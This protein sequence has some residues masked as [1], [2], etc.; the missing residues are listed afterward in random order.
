MRRFR[1]RNNHGRKPTHFG[2]IFTRRQAERRATTVATNLTFEVLE[3]RLQMAVVI[4]EFLAANS[5]GLADQDGDRS[6]WIELRNSDA[7]PVDLGG[8]YLTDDV[9]DLDKWQIPSTNLPGGG[10]LVIFAS[11]KDRAVSGQEL[12][13]NFSLEQ[14]G[15]FLALVMPDGTT[16][17][18][19]F[20]PFP[21]QLNDVSYGRGT[22]SIITESPIG[23]DAPL[24]VLVPQNSS[25]ATT[26]YTTGFNDSGWMSGTSGVGFDINGGTDFTPYVGTNIQTA[27]WNICSSAYI[28][29]PFDVA[30]GGELTTLKLRMR[31]DDGFLVYLNGSEMVSAGRNA[32]PSAPNNING[33]AAGSRNDPSAIV[34]EDIDLTSFRNLLLPGANVLGIHALNSSATSQD[35][36]IDPLLV[37]ERTGQAVVGYMA[38]PTP[39]AANSQDTLGFV[40]DTTFSV[41]R[42]FYESPFNVEI[43]TATAG[44]EIRYTVDGSLPTAT[45]GLVYNPL[46]PPLITTTTT[47]R[48]AAFKVGYTPSNVDTQTYIFL[49]NVIHQS[50]AGL[51]AVAAWG[52][53][54]NADGIYDPD[55]AMDPDIVNNPLYSG[56]IKNDLKAVPTVSLVMPWNDWF[57]SGGQGIYPTE[58]EIERPTSM[59]FFTADGSQDFQI[60]A[61]IE[62]QGGTS[63]DRWKMDK[64]SMRVKFKALYGSTKL[65]ANLFQ[66]PFFDEGATVNFDTLILD[67]QSNYTWAYG[68]GLDNP[69]QRTRTMFI[70][71]QVIADLQNLAGGQAPHGR[72]VHLYINGLYWGIYMLHER[73]DD[74]FA[75]AYLGGDKDDY[76]AIKHNA[77]TVVAGDTTA[78]PNYAALLNLVRQ[79]MTVAANY[80]TV[81]QKLDIDEFID[82]MIINYYGGNTDWAKKNWYA[83]Y[84]RVDPNGKWRFHS[85]DAEHVF[86]VPNPT[87]NAQLTSN[88]SLW[89]SLAAQ[90]NV[91]GANNT[92]GPTEI[93]Q[94]LAANPEYRLRFVDRVQRL[95]YNGGLLTPTE[96]AAVYQA[97]M[98]EA[99]RAIVGESARWGDNHTTASEPPGA[100]GA[101]TRDHW[102]ATQND[103]LANYFP[104]RGNVVLGQFSVQGWTVP[105]AAPLFSNYGG[106]VMSGY[107]LCLSMP[108]GTPADAAIYYTIDGSDPRDPVTNLPKASAFVYS[109]PITINAGTR[110]NARIYLDDPPTSAVYEWSPVVEATFLMETPF[111]LRITEINYH[112]ADDPGV[113]DDDDL[114]F[115][116]LLNT[117]SQMVRL[118]GV[119]IARFAATPY[120][121]GGGIDLDAGERILVARN[122]AVFQSVYGTGLNVAAA[123]YGPANLSNDGERVVLLG[124]LGETLQDFTFDDLAPW[125]TAADGSGSSL[126]IID[127][128]GDPASASNWRASATSG[129][130]PG[131]GGAPTPLAGDYDHNGTVEDADHGVWKA[132]F[133]MTVTPGSG[134][135]GN[136]DGTVD[137]VDYVVWRKN[138][139]ATQPAAAAAG[140]GA[141]AEI[142]AVG[143]KGNGSLFSIPH[144]MQS[145]DY[146]EDSRPPFPVARHAAPEA[147]LLLASIIDD[148]ARQAAR[149]NSD[150]DGALSAT[151]D[152]QSD[153]SDRIWQDLDWLASLRQTVLRRT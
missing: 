50:G 1:N 110:V 133:G 77:T 150:H 33:T 37:A 58:A 63:D 117:G 149:S 47:L 139:G 8:W 91:T 153:Q 45:T 104:N 41:D 19:S 109:T 57:G 49:D 31:Y 30:N 51:P 72:I 116:E 13:T 55:W 25:V 38:T 123:G 44:A 124:P 5:N 79:D 96:V 3:P 40:D 85:W 89:P 54:I 80:S 70:Q 137:L 99:D 48:A 100:G 60:D 66:N 78:V 142:V 112:P 7:S 23:E 87:Q 143:D 102:L 108:G 136:G 86:K 69:Y 9:N 26:W 6:D 15:E 92:G 64:L 68:G 56:T 125:P 76:D 21:G 132:S 97:R 119:Q 73:P 59:E 111:P 151:S 118:A 34:Y 94:R 14:N 32:S 106:T 81:E 84:N 88:P 120:V 39:G 138:L 29:I 90:A 144:Q 35:L 22:G 36:L 2:K 46:S 16:I 82:Y 121:F 130:S 134:A 24:K 126:E 127:P 83:T 75:E 141:L 105:L 148:R 18:D 107:S 42:G 93:Q 135:D 65:D 146:K 115:I 28:R 67:A 4:N 145:T 113:P 103:L 114:E 71:D 140:A 11:G 52:H 129:G 12:H 62:I 61:G 43:T 10:Y 53:D 27:M 122:P 152:A 131:S 147:S 20:A 74:S 101:Y 128:L 95:M 98:Q 17:A